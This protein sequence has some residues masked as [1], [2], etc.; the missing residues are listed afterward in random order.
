M[1][2]LL[3]PTPA[4]INSQECDC[5]WVRRP[6]GGSVIW[7]DIPR[8][9]MLIDCIIESTRGHTSIHLTPW[10]SRAQYKR[11]N[12]ETY[13][14]HDKASHLMDRFHAAE[15]RARSI[16]QSRCLSLH[17]MASVGW[18]HPSHRS[19]PHQEHPAGHHTYHDEEDALVHRNLQRSG[20]LEDMPEDDRTGPLDRPARCPSDS[21]MY[22]D[23][24]HSLGRAPTMADLGHHR[25]DSC[26]SSLVPYDEDSNPEEDQNQL[27]LTPDQMETED[28]ATAESS[29]KKG[30]GIAVGPGNYQP[31]PPR[32]VRAD[33]DSE[34]G[35]D[36]DE[37]GDI[38]APYLAPKQTPVP[39]PSQDEPT[40]QAPSKEKNPP[41]EDSQDSSGE[42]SIPELIDFREG[43]EVP[44]PS[45][46]KKAN[47]P[48]TL[49]LH[50]KIAV[51]SEKLPAFSFPPLKDQI[52]ALP[53]A[54]PEIHPEEVPEEQIIYIDDD[55]DPFPLCLLERQVDHL[56]MPP[57][58]DT[59]PM[60]QKAPKSPSRDHQLPRM[61]ER[62]RHSPCTTRKKTLQER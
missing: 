55:A 13:K 15:R 17:H 47:R 2:D 46:L 61:P 18:I 14:L 8:D 32:Y 33:E 21:P 6:M 31:A 10:E 27:E 41:A 60:A 44:P 12:Q 53:A 59:T 25:P 58:S 36:T 54:S 51:T 1:T 35:Q 56:L 30:M 34:D 52:K 29:V 62:R 7:L 50:K 23:A 20:W 39:I 28:P 38:E 24:L 22:E 3:L 4:S 9:T 26:S 45:L 48:T 40:A 43:E 11:W 57:L 16:Q 37:E 49:G 5:K 42:E 19:G